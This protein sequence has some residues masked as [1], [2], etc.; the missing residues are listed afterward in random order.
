MV[1]EKYVAQSKQGGK[2]PKSVL[3]N[4]EVKAMVR[5]KEVLAAKD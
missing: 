4:N 1:Q 5:R 3:W 2:N